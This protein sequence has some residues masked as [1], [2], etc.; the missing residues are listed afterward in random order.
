MN[1][2]LDVNICSESLSGSDELLFDDL[3]LESDIQIHHRHTAD[4]HLN[5]F[6]YMNKA[7]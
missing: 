1:V 6:A 4:G 2:E 5:C 7:Y 3:M